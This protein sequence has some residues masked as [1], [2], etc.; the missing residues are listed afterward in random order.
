MFNE[1]LTTHKLIEAL[2]TYL[3]VGLNK[4]KKCPT[5]DNTRRPI[6]LANII[7]KT[8]LNIVLER[9]RPHLH[10]FVSRAYQKDRHAPHIIWSYQW[11]NAMVQNIK[12]YMR[13]LA[14]IC[15]RHLIL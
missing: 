4:P 2:L 11:I 13:L 7:R 14:S 5:A 1:M 3:I 6:S 8:F 12:K 10:N 15:Q 9:V